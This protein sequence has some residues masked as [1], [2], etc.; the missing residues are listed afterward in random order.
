MKLKADASKLCFAYQAQL[1][2]ILKYISYGGADF[3]W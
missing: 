3:S 1:F 2:Y